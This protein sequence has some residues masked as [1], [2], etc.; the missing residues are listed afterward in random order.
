LLPRWEFVAR[1][2]YLCE[3][4]CFQCLTGQIRAGDRGAIESCFLHLV[5]TIDP[6]PTA[7]GDWTDLLLLV[8]LTDALT[9][10]RGVTPDSSPAHIERRAP[11]ALSRCQLVFGHQRGAIFKAIQTG[12]SL[13]SADHAEVMDPHFP[14]IP[15]R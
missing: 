12:G 7:P 15:G 8:I 1:L 14:H 4:P 3:G 10:P 11:I 6:F 5:T 9:W 13:T 2:G